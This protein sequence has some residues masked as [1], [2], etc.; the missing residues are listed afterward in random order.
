M[1]TFVLH[2]GNCE[3]FVYTLNAH[4]I[5]DALTEVRKIIF[6]GERPIR[7]IKTP[8]GYPTGSRYY[9]VTGVKPSKNNRLGTPSKNFLMIV[10][11]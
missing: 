7:K 6:A 10:R 2:T 5:K 4:N 3:Q 11:D 9:R 1:T 8:P